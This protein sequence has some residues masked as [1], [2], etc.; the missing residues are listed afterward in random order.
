MPCQNRQVAQVQDSVLLDSICPA[1]AEDSTRAQ[2]T[3]AKLQQ[4]PL[5]P[6]CAFLARFWAPTRTTTCLRPLW[7]HHQKSP[8][9]QRHWVSTGRGQRWLAA[10]NQRGYGRPQQ[11]GPWVGKLPHRL[12]LVPLAVPWK[13][14]SQAMHGATMSACVVA[15]S[16]IPSTTRCP[17]HIVFYAGE[18]EAPVEWN[19]GPN[20]YVYWVCNYL[21]GPLSRLPHVTPAQVGLWLACFGF[22]VVI[23][24]GAGSCWGWESVTMLWADAKGRV[25]SPCSATVIASWSEEGTLAWAGFAPCQTVVSLQNP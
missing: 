8:Q 4:T 25:V 9:S 17:S 12:L 16:F 13:G 19:S 22:V 15:R 14:P 20:A 5:Y 1:L 24:W 6:R 18:G 23:Q 2:Q 7:Q 11:Q 21:G 10:S 3:P